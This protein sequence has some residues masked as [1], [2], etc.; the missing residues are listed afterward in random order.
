LEPGDGLGPSGRYA[1]SAVYDSTRDRVLLYGG[2]FYDYGTGLDPML[3]QLN[4]LWSLTFK[5]RTTWKP[6][7]LDVAPPPG[8]GHSLILDPVADRLIVFGGTVPDP[9]DFGPVDIDS[10]EVWQIPLSAA[11]SATMLATGDSMPSVRESH[12]AIYDP[13]RRRMIVFGGCHLPE[14]LGDV[15]AL[16][17]DASP[18]WTRLE[19]TGPGPE[20]RYGHCAIYDPVGDRMI[21]FGG[22]NGTTSFADT[23]QLTLAGTPAWSPLPSAVRPPAEV[24]AC[25]VYDSRRQRI[26]LVGNAEADGETWVFPLADGTGWQPAAITGDSPAPRDAAT[27]VFD[28][29]ED[30]VVL[31]D[32]IQPTRVLDYDRV[33]WTM[34]S[35]VPVPVSVGLFSVHAGP[36]RVALHWQAGSGSTITAAVERRTATSAW[37]ALGTVA[38]DATGMLA[39]D[40]MTAA[41]GSRYGYR[42]VWAVGAAARTTP[43]TWVDVPRL[44]LALVGSVPDPATQGL[45]VLFSLPDA[46]AARLEV[47][48]I[49][50]RR[51]RSRD[52]GSLGPGDHVLGLAAPGELRPGVYFTRLTRGAESVVK[53]VSVI[54]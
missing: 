44:G 27:A 9:S 51:V 7:V 31:L 37:T 13:I 6:I 19:A 24:A 1:H 52:V 54:R 15:W 38:S 21:V 14:V 42:L 23:W 10:N 5:P 34:A 12:T 49:A 16:S 43:E 18:R 41:P 25:M 53:R 46:S 22:R 32:G 29:A 39:Y 33:V 11:A 17:L 2:E 26:V 36:F 28:L 20:P 40:D 3:Y 8:A 45:T 4:D 48:D 30:R 35:A 50:G 47:V